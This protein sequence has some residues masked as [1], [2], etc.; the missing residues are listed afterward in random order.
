MD[1]KGI[2]V[3]MAVMARA[4]IDGRIDCKT[5]GRVVVQLQTLSK[6][7]RMLDRTKTK[8]LPRMISD[9]T[10]L[11]ESAGA[12]EPTHDTETIYRK[13]REGR[14]ENQVLP[15]ICAVERRL[16]QPEEKA[17]LTTESRRHGEQP[18]AERNWTAIYL[19]AHHWD[20]QQGDTQQGEETR[21]A[22]VTKVRAFAD[23]RGWGHAPPELLRA[24]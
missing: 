18:P 15:Q 2:Q 3:T 5:A 10:D 17:H 20:T 6:L 23:R 13:V 19:A 14:K 16:G 4:L 1:L 12:E 22:S 11:K 24:A 21:V 9:N 7:L 8:A